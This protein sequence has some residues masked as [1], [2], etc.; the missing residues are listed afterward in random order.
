[1]NKNQVSPYYFSTTSPEYPLLN[2]EHC[3]VNKFNQ[4]IKTFHDYVMKTRTN[5][6]AENKGENHGMQGDN[7]VLAPL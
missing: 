6:Y 5:Y 4:I 1:M 2:R 7:E 3:F